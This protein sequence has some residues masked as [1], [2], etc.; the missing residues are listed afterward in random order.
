ML[1]IDFLGQSRKE[2]RKWGKRKI[3]KIEKSPKNEVLPKC[4]V[5]STYE[6]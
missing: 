5:H 3:P 6:V 1:R 4:E 2:R